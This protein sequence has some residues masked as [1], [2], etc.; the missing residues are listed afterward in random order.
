MTGAENLA[1]SVAHVQVEGREVYLVG[2]AHVSRESVADVRATIEQIGP[3]TV[4]VELCEARYEALVRREVWRQMDIFKIVREKKSVLLLAQLILT[5]FYRRLGDKLGVQPGT[6]MLEAVKLAEGRGAKIV[7]ADRDIR[8]TLKRVYG[9][10]SF[11]NKLK[12]ATHLLAGLFA[13]EEISAELVENLKKKDQLEAVMSEFTDKFPE[14]KKRLIDERDIY[15]SQKIRQAGGKKVV[16]VVGAGHV[17][18]ISRHI[19]G[20]EPVEELLSVPRGSVW[21]KILKWGLPALI[22]GIVV[23]G[24]FRQGAAETAESIYIWIL[25]NGLFSAAGAAA[26][27]GHPLTVVSAFFAAPVTSLNP[28][29]AAGWVAGL[30]QAWVRRPMVTDFENL[31]EAIS[32]VKGFWMNPVTK[33]LLV[34]ALANLGSVIGTWVAGTWIAARS[35]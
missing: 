32:T 9:Y 10:L 29:I 17:E 13:G 14:I 35:V 8:I 6:E 4:A 19:M 30:V 5:S 11:W 12:L 23:Y 33:I 3:D 2:T 31:G 34:V 18:G 15:I 21:P 26:A 20:S 16:A 28:T 22:I 7:L 25:V 24:F 1:A 27:L